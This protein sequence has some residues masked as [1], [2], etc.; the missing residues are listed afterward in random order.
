MAGTE[1]AAEVVDSLLMS[2]A[3][4]TIPNDEGQAATDVVGE[5]VEEADDRLLK[6]S[7]PCA[8]CWG[9]LQPT[10]YGVAGATWGCTALIPT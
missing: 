3:A 5:A 8:R 4:E 10:G 6:E 1:R 7:T 9:T 2:D